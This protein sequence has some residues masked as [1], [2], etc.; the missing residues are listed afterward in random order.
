MV[1]GLRE[2]AGDTPPVK[3]LH[4]MMTIVMVMVWA[5]GQ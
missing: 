3:A 1:V 4:V 5:K 2:A